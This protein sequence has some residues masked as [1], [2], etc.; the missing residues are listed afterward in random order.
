M[1]AGGHVKMVSDAAP[2]AHTFV[3]GNML[4]ALGITGFRM[5][6]LYPGLQ[7]TA[8]QG[9]PGVNNVW[10]WGVSGP[11]KLPADIV[12]KWEDAMQELLKDPEY[13]GKITKSGGVQRTGEEGE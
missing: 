5:P 11:P 8:E 7:T 1:V 12:K 3:S 6:A 2:S 4:R 10:W 13:V 9:Y